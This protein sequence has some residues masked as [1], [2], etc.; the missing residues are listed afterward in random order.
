MIGPD[1]LFIGAVLVVN[2]LWLAG[3][4]L[5]AARATDLY[6][7]DIA[8]E[9]EASAEQGG[10]SVT[11][12]RT[13]PTMPLRQQ[14]RSIVLGGKE[15]GFFNLLVGLLSLTLAMTMIIQGGIKGASLTSGNLAWSFGLL[16]A[17]TYL[18]VAANQFL[19][20]DGRA[21]GW[22]CMFVALTAIPLGIVALSRAPTGHTWPIWLGINWII[23]GVLW[24]MFWLLLAFEKGDKF[25][26]ITGVVTVL[27]GIG[28][29]WLPAFLLLEGYIP[30]S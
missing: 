18:W 4:V 9:T 28:T 2:G 3:S 7:S 8:V 21:F 17:F 23:W 30:A 11:A 14:G 19:G 20:A 12:V 22:Y 5:P 24:G 13:R 10:G 25:T 26:T 27:V 16:F 1:L 6:V 15:V 29:C